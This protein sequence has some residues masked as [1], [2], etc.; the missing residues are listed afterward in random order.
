[1]N[2]EQLINI[3]SEM[4]F[5]NRILTLTPRISGQQKT[6]PFGDLTACAG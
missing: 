1:M 6:Q 5:D 4:T 2:F 3:K